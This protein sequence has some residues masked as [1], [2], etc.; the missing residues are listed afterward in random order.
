MQ[1]SETGRQLV[2]SHLSQLLNIIVSFALHKSAGR[3]FIYGDLQKL[4]IVLIVLP[5]NI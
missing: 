4:T 5:S 1:I 2:A 3:F